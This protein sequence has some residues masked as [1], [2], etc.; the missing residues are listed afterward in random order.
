MTR[1]FFLAI[2]SLLLFNALAQKSALEFLA[3]VPEL[4][5]DPCTADYLQKKEFGEKIQKLGDSVRAELETRQQESEQFQKEHQDEEQINILMKLGY[6]REQADKLKNADRMS[7]AE[8]MAIANEM[9]MNRN[10]MTVEDYQKVA[11]YDTAAQR[12]WAKANSTMEMADMD[13]QENEK[14]QLKL[15]QDFDLQSELMLQRDKIR[16]GEDKYM[17]QI[18]KLDKEADTTRIVLDKQIE[19]A[20]KDLEN[21]NNDQ[22]RDQIKGRMTQLMDTYCKKFTPKYLEIIGQFKVYIQQNLNEYDKWEEL[23]I[24]SV[25]SQTGVK[26]PNYKTG[27]MSV[28]IVV[29][30][31]N[32]LSNAFKYSLNN[33]LGL[34][35]FD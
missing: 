6:T 4:T 29:S 8:Q 23:Q 3:E 15:N 31:M 33:N 35:I 34:P 9:L 10:N 16:A 30:Y 20:Q 2:F 13:T 22:Q 24:K 11:E 14:E 21:C 26:N 27:T 32:L 18:G 7:E 5:F 1:F 25:E 28:G 12:R 17:Q 19:K